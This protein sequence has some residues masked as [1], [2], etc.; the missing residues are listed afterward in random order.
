MDAI[1]PQWL[2]VLK[3]R[4]HRVAEIGRVGR[5]WRRF[6]RMIPTVVFEDISETRISPKERGVCNGVKSIVVL[7]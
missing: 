5:I 1:P 6:G 4:G 2:V 7:P 3:H